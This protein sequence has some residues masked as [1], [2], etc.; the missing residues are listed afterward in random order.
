[1]QPGKG[2]NPAANLLLMCFSA[3]MDGTAHRLQ[4]PAIQLCMFE[5]FSG[6]CITPAAL[7]LFAAFDDREPVIAAAEVENNPKPFVADHCGSSLLSSSSHGAFVV[8]GF[9]SCSR[10]LAATFS[11]QATSSGLARSEEH[12]SERQSLRHLVCR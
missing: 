4:H 7:M 10:T 1:M 2:A 6:R 11:C 8:I 5:S 3:P 9:F 12:K